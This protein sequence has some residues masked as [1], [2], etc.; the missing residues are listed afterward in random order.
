MVLGEILDHALLLVVVAH[1]FESGNVI[2]QHHNM[3]GETVKEKEQA[4]S[5]RHAAKY[6]VQVG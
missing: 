6:H 3:R 2:I 1:S 4:R 5:L